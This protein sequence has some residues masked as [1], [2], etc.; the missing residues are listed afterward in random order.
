M[1]E[2]NI[3]GLVLPIDGEKRKHPIC[4][5]SQGSEV[6]KDHPWHDAVACI[7]T[8]SFP[9]ELYDYFFPFRLWGCS[10]FHFGILKRFALKSN[11]K[12]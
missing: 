4:R 7:A 1:E 6:G 9:R 3:V 8:L 10:C 11:P 12:N 5:V 2:G